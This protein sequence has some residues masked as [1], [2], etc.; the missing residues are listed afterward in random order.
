MAD[1]ATKLDSAL[2]ESRQHGQLEYPVGVYPLNM[3]AANM[4]SIP[5]HWHDEVELNIV[6]KGKVLFMA[7]EHSTV[8]TAGQGQFVNQAILHSIKPADDTSACELFSIVFHPGFLFGYGSTVMTAK[9]LTPIITSKQ[10]KRFVLNPDIDW[11]KRILDASHT[12]AERHMA[13]EFGYELYVQAQLC[14]IWLEILENFASLTS[15]D[16]VPAK[17]ANNLLIDEIRV[18]TAMDYMEKHHNESITL[19]DIAASA[20]ISKSECCRCFKRTLK[21]TPFEYL[22]RY[23]IFEATRKMQDQ[24]PITQSISGLAFSVGF[25]NTSYFN[26]LFKQYLHCT[27]KEYKKYLLLHPDKPMDDEFHLL[28]HPKQTANDRYA[29]LK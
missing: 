20:H 7:G 27:P 18:K 14:N 26:K 23:R 24:D 25:N 29:V 8:L 11:Q 3:R 13:H 10:L 17:T 6:V 4:T 22:M 9:Y 2:Y 28:H 19:D 16:D 15:L 5:W 21:L 12:I 1:K